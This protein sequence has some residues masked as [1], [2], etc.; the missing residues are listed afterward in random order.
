MLPQETLQQYDFDKLVRK[1][2]NGR[3]RLCLMALAHLKKGKRYGLG[4]GFAR[5][6]SYR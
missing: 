2:S 4:H 6:P 5:Y 1:E 3:R